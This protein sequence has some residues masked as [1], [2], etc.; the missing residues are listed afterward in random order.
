MPL[1][2]FLT[3][4]IALCVVPLLLLAIV[5]A[6]A[7][8]HHI[9]D[10]NQVEAEAIS[11]SL[12]IAI[13]NNLN[14]RI[15][16]LQ[17]LAM[18]PLANDGAHRNTLYQ[19]AQGYRD[20]LGS[21]V[22]FVDSNMRM[23]FNTRLPFGAPMPALPQPTGRSAVLTAQQTLK[24]AVG[25]P[26]MG[27]V[28]GEPL[29]AIAA[30]VV[31]DNVMSHFLITTIETRELKHAIEQTVLPPGWAV[32]LQDGT[33]KMIAHHGSTPAHT[34]TNDVNAKRFVVKSS[35][36]P[37][38][39]VL[40]I[41]RNIYF[42]PLVNAIGALVVAIL[43]ATL[44]AILGGKLAARRLG[45]AVASLADAPGSPQPS[46]AIAEIGT[47]R[48][49]LDDA[50]DKR[51]QAETA[52]A[53]SEQQARAAIEAAAHKLALSE[54][55][56]R[57]IFDSATDAIITADES[58]TIVMANSAAADIFRCALDDVMGAPLERFIPARHREQ[59]R[60]HVQ[61]FGSA[62]IKARHVGSA[63][64]VMGLRAGGEEFPIDAAISHLTVD[65]HRLYTVILRDIS[66]RVRD[67]NEL[68]RYADIVES[69]GDAILSRLSDGTVI[70]WNSAAQELF[71]YT[72]A[73]MIGKPVSVLYS[74]HTPPEEQ[75]LYARAVRGERIVNFEKRPG[76]RENC[77]M[78][79]ARR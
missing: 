30:P 62:E 70:T 11:K 60:R 6:I 8:V 44:L 31:R 56:L 20:S 32:A 77:T 24:P 13:D 3:Q 25:D 78:N 40:E 51:S 59:H 74:P 37:W 5:L 16:G 28:A 34:D 14:A 23:V 26:F 41:P 64:L 33:G 39:V 42:A 57:G 61:A 48:R 17:I 50:Y 38:S 27:P 22:V 63:R 2:R 58:Q 54:A 68:Q 4:L 47:V 55:R 72:G 66:E 18:S 10:E 71:G 76:L 45:K 15:A 65:G 36:S 21:H 67:R 73:E 52:R 49:M 29:V 53:N 79:W 9:Q 35:A 1:N 7:Y 43:L 69:S 75:D 12:M 46:D 19:E